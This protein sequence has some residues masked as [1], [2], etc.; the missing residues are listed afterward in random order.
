M[1]YIFFGLGFFNVVKKLMKK[2][3]ENVKA[4]NVDGWTPIHFAANNGIYCLLTLYLI[5]Y[6]FIYKVDSTKKIIPISGHYKIVKL[7]ISYSFNP[8]APS[9][10]G[11]TPIHLASIGGHLEIIKLLLTYTNSA[12]EQDY[13][14]VTPI[15]LAA[16][17][18]VYI[19]I[20]CL[21]I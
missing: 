19:L 9:I 12:N 6:W 7:L 18:F 21:Q 11:T 17:K 8:N 10:V 14:G 15:H 13:F 16:G 3:P 4:T 5:V 2:N 20:V 1:V